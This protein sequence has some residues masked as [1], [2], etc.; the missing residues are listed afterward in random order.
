MYTE[1][2]IVTVSGREHIIWRDHLEQGQYSETL[3]YDD[4]A[5]IRTASV[6]CHQPNFTNKAWFN[7][8]YG[9][10][11]L[12]N[13]VARWDHLPMSIRSRSY[14][15]DKSTLVRFEHV[16]H[17]WKANILT[18]RMDSYIYDVCWMRKIS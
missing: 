8:C 11:T 7:L 5:R 17:G 18:P 3:G 1:Q 15:P 6:Q 2:T 14:I 16:F 13:G 10:Q 12:S 4:F 9:F